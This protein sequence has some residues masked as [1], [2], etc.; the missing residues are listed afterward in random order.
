VSRSM[1]SYFRISQVNKNDRDPLGM[2]L[3]R[4]HARRLTVEVNYD[5]AKIAAAPRTMQAI[6][7]DIAKHSKDVADSLD[8]I[9]STLT[10]LT[11]NWS[12]NSQK[13]ADDLNH[14]WSEAMQKLFGSK[15]DPDAGV[16]NA[17]ADGIGFTAGNYGKAETG[18]KKLFDDFVSKLSGGDADKNAVPVDHLDKNE[19]AITADY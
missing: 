18:V 6:A 3:I 8:R 19:T 13:E 16:L 12:S 5:G 17:I 15:G 11:L 14:R 2:P 9:N 1:R 10:A 7:K 4:V